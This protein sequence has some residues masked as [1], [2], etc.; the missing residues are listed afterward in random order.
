MEY[1][2]ALDWQHSSRYDVERVSEV[3]W[4]AGI[5]LITSAWMSIQIHSTQLLLKESE[6]ACERIVEEKDCLG[7][8]G[9][10]GGPPDLHA[11]YRAPVSC[12]PLV[13]LPA[14]AGPGLAG[15]M[16]VGCTTLC[17]FHWLFLAG[18]GEQAGAAWVPGA[19][20]RQVCM[21]LKGP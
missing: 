3:L 12:P 19:C 17:E 16:R 14:S 10:A 1:A 11:A 6:L 8:G 15:F 9:G 13:W 5:R 20:G 7:G 18:G 4:T 21:L 2:W